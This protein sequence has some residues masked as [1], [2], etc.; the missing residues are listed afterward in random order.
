[1]K[2]LKPTLLFIGMLW[3]TQTDARINIT[4]TQNKAALQQNFQQLVA[5]YPAWEKASISQ[6]PVIFNDLTGDHQFYLYEIINENKNLG[7]C[8]VGARKNLPFLFEASMAPSPLKQVLTCKQLMIRKL[9]LSIDPSTIKQEFI[10][11]L[12]G[13]FYVKFT[14]N[15][16]VYIYN[17]LN[18][19]LMD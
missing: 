16:S 17:L 5:I 1:M 2:M 8:A 11:T 4:V 15:R 7:Y 6:V 13:S 14:I 18:C 3:V 19:Q 10:T 12:P 9:Y